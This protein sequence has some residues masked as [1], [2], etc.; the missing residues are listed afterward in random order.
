MNRD[1][2]LELIDRLLQQKESGATVMEPDESRLPVSVYRSQER[3]KAEQRVLFRG[4][5]T[6]I[7][8]SSEVASPGDFITHDALGVPLLIQRDRDGVLRAFL[9]VCRHRGSRLVLEPR[10]NKKGI[11]CGYHGWTYGMDGGLL[12]IPHPEGF[13]RTDCDRGLVPVGVEERAG[14][15]WVQPEPRSTIDVA[16][17]LGPID[18][19]LRGFELGGYVPNRHEAMK[20]RFNWKLIIASYTGIRSTGSSWT[21]S[22]SPTRSRRTSAPSWRARDWSRRGP[23][24]AS[25]GSST[26]SCR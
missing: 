5:P 12:H 21:T 15:I 23:C 11:V 16:K 4:H 17:F 24:R 2:E 1:M 19:E 6:I 10:G 25:P 9:N 13:P 7:A 14:F 8:H 3:F 18:D 22:T 20:R 26:T